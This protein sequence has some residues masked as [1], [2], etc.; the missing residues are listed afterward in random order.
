MNVVQLKRFCRG[1]PNA[2]ETLYG[3]PYNFLV[4]SV[5]GKKFASFKTSDPQRWGSPRSSEAC[6]RFFG[7][8]IGNTRGRHGMDELGGTA[9]RTSYWYARR[10]CA[11]GC[12]LRSAIGVGNG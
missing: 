8:S 2:I 1:F 6:G 3:D 7:C 9:A 5:G 11:G 12:R 4:Y 10:A